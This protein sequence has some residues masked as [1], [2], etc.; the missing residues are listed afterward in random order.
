MDKLQKV[1]DNLDL[2]E[3]G[4]AT[5][6]WIEELKDCFNANFVIPIQDKNRTFLLGLKDDENIHVIDRKEFYRLQP[7]ASEYSVLTT[8]KKFLV[9][10]KWNFF[11]GFVENRS[12]CDICCSKFYDK[13]EHI[14]I[15]VE[16]AEQADNGV[17]YFKCG[18]CEKPVLDLD[19]ESKHKYCF[20]C[21]EYNTGYEHLDIDEDDDDGWGPQLAYVRRMEEYPIKADVWYKVYPY[22]RIRG[23]GG[24]FYTWAEGG[25]PIVQFA[26]ENQD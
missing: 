8:E 5:K 2:S 10:V 16:C 23:D 9:Y 14:P 12:H 24:K 17:F 26:V 19:E 6:K 3:E 15:C 4:L 21:V 20:D 13:G 7:R 25:A 1:A 22:S 11:P 18:K